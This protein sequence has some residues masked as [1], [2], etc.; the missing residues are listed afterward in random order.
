MLVCHN[1]RRNWANFRISLML[2]SANY[3]VN[4]ISLFSKRPNSQI[5]NRLPSNWTISLTLKSFKSLLLSWSNRWCKKF[6]RSRMKLRKKQSRRRLQTRILLES[7]SSQMRSCLKKFGPS[8]KNLPSLLVN[9]TRSLS[10]VIR[11]WSNTRQVSGMIFSPC[12]SQ[13]KRTPN[14]QTNSAN[15]SLTWRL[16]RK[17][18]TNLGPRLRLRFKRWCHKQNSQRQSATS[19]PILHKSCLTWEANFSQGSRSSTHKLWMW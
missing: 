18:W 17:I 1:M 2:R 3:K 19:T 7:K 8:R 11:L 10:N 16:I 12:C 14:R 13:S 6:P 9:L 4:W 5:W 15:H